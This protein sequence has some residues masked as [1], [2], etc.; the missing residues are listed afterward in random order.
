MKRTR[1]GFTLVELLVVIAILAILAT[2]SVVGYTSFIERAEKSNIE[3]EAHQVESIIS[4]ALIGKEAVQ[5]KDK[6]GA[7]YYVTKTGVSTSVT[8]IDADKIA[9]VTGDIGE[10]NAKLE[11]KNGAL[12][13]GHVL[14]AGT[15]TAGG[16][17]SGETTTT[18]TTT[19][20]T[21]D[22]GSGEPEE[23]VVLYLVPN[24]NWKVDNARFAAYFFNDN[25]NTWVD[26]TD[27]DGD[28]TYECVAPDGYPNVI[29]VRMNPTTT[30]NNFDNEVKWNQTG[31]LTVPTDDKVKFVVTPDWWDAMGNECWTTK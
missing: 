26:M 29:F 24:A 2:V 9:D 16:E 4:S 14:V 21:N 12:Y 17:G 3:T 10:L 13:Y 19:T 30:E 23:D 8:G 5:L 7:T 6:D 27:E 15:P 31:D 11:V 1:K 20:T 28:G 18:T 22:A 25:S